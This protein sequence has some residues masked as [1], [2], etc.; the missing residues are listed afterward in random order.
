[1]MVGDTF[2]KANNTFLDV[3]RQPADTIAVTLSHDN[4][5]HE[6]LDGADTLKRDLALSGGLVKTKLVTL[7]EKSAL[8]VITPSIHT[9]HTSWSSLTALGSKSS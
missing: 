1:M 6:N 5:A 3:L 7:I 2:K 9:I 4:T 8:F